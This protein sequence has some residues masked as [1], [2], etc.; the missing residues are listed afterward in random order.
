MVQVIN[1][2]VVWSFDGAGLTISD[3]APLDNPLM[4]EPIRV[5]TAAI[6]GVEFRSQ[7]RSGL[8]SWL[9]GGAVGTVEL[10][11]RTGADPL[12]HTA[13]G[14]LSEKSDPY[15]LNVGAAAQEDAWELVSQIHN[16]LAHHPPPDTPV[17]QYLVSSPAIPLRMEID[18]IAVEFDGHDLSMQFLPPPFVQS[19]FN[20]W[21]ERLIP[22]DRR[23]PLDVVEWVEWRP[24]VDG[25]DGLVRVHLKDEPNPLLPQHDHNIIPLRG[26][27]AAD[28]QGLRLAAAMTALLPHPLA[29]EGAF[30]VPAD[31]EDKVDTLLHR[32][33][34]LGR[35]HRDG[36]LT[37]TEFADLKET[38]IARM[39]PRP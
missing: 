4:E 19:S 26:S 1:D 5:P 13:R 7:E 6:A 17:A 8:R 25:Y 31:G 32:L 33:R 23:Y 28:E 20:Q 24:K 12:T 37:D 22:F 10:H 18:W 9:P 15:R 29:D 36:V 27:I 11:L 35:L 30:T 16:A 21:L 38:V 2:N 3:D 34:E 39:S 14:M